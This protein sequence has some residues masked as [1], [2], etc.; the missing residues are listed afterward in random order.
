VVRLKF[1]IILLLSVSTFIIPLG[2]YSLSTVFQS[3]HFENNCTIHH[4]GGARTEKQENE[5][6]NA[7]PVVTVVKI[8]YKNKG[9]S[10]NYKAVII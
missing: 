7:F 2:K 6:L 10:K 4:S 5:S 3:L 9:T 1:P 8:V